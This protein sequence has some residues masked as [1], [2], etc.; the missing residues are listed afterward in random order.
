MKKIWTIAVALMLILTAVAFSSCGECEHNYENGKCTECELVCEH[1]EY[2]NGA[3][4]TCGTAC[5][6]TEYA[7]GACKT[8]GTACAHTEYA[9]GACKECGTVCTHEEYENG[10]CKECGTVCTHEEYENSAC[11]ECGTVCTHEAY[12]SGVC[13]ECGFVCSHTYETGI[14]TVCGVVCSHT[15]EDGTCT[16]CGE[17]CVHDYEEGVCSI[18]GVACVHSYTNGTC[19]VC[20]V[21]CSHSEYDN[22]I[23]KEC[24][25]ACTHESYE[26]GACTVCNKECL[27]NSFGNGICKVC[28]TPCSHNYVNSVCEICG[29]ACSH[30]SYDENS[31]CE[32][33][34][35]K[36]VSHTYE[37]GAC[38]EC[39]KAD[40]D[41]RSYYN[42][43]VKA[44]R[45]IIF[46]KNTYEELPPEEAEAPFYMEAL[47]QVAALYDPSIEIGYAFKD[48]NN[49]GSAEL[50]LIGRDSRLYAL[51]TV[52]DKSVKVVRVFQNGMGYL[53]RTGMVFYN[54][55]ELDSLEIQIHLENHMTRLVGDKLVGFE[56]SRTDLD[57]DST[58]E[59]D[60]I[61]YIITEDGT[62]TEIT[63]DEYKIYQN[64]TYEYYW[65]YPTRVTKLS[66]LRFMP[67]LIEQ[68][69][70]TKTADFSSYEKIIETFGVMW[71]EVGNAKFVKSAW[72]AGDYD[73]GMLFNSDEDFYMYN[74]I[75]GS[76]TL[77]GNTG[78]TTKYGH[79]EK[80]LNG[81]GVN[82]LILLD[83]KQS[84]FAIF[85][86][87]DGKP[88]LLDNYNDIR[89]AF[90]D[91]DGLIHV[92]KRIIP[93][94]SKKD[95]EYSVYKLENNQLVATVVFGC[96][97]TAG[98]T[99]QDTW[100][101]VEGGVRT[102][103]SKDAFT[104]LYDQ[105]IK[106]IGTTINNTNAAK[107]T[108]NNAGL[109]LVEIEK[110]EEE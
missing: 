69:T 39:G 1:S 54:V 110:I 55:K 91:A 32:A 65:G 80:D 105:Y 109:T 27:H 36:C 90:I 70:A 11:K 93:A 35:K 5:A 77:L 8:C 61:F 50:I 106:I 4:K 42:D 16:V 98:T 48:I 7:N 89:Y 59:E 62:R 56:Y 30:D 108:L 19:S 34:G 102:D 40:P 3:C 67:A 6:H 95:F 49:D 58:T 84:V 104:E 88:V 9:N 73:N 85:T 79:A 96:E 21:V 18:C 82:E 44:Y 45:E 17:S 26:N 75:I 97:C 71:A 2:A 28:G 94:D 100:Y 22:G 74:A 60:E 41:G 43:V 52:V 14:C 29:T 24:G 99:T 38:D 101:K 33:C 13:Q 51:F 53:D 46:Y 92:I 78:S 68:I 12:E 83:S 15:F 86:L 31:T 87:V 64:Y 81:D 47:R 10:A 20:G 103:I 76:A 23:C 63:Y 107:Y 57:G 72:A 66:N 25:F 37:N